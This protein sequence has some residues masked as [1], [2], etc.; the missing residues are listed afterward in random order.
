MSYILFTLCGIYYI[1]ALRMFNIY[2]AYRRVKINYASSKRNHRKQS[3]TEE[4][5]NIH[6]IIDRMSRGQPQLIAFFLMS[7]RKALKYPNSH[8]LAERCCCRMLNC[9]D[10]RQIWLQE[11]DCHVNNEAKFPRRQ[12]HT[13][14]RRHTMA[15]WL[16]PRDK[17]A[18]VSNVVT[19][20]NNTRRSHLI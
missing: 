8:S 14:I 20:Y 7:R 2:S 13:C 11:Y 4:K 6:L 17:T 5:H 1:S 9:V 3:I 19:Q 10:S 16:I 18:H 12:V 15:H